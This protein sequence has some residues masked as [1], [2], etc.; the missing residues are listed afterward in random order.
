M[1]KVAVERFLTRD[2]PRA[3]SG[4]TPQGIIPMVR[5]LSLWH[6]ATASLALEGVRAMSREDL[7]RNIDNPKKKG[8]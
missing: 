1:D 7:T 5:V 2:L 3:P 8:S 4:Q 6:S